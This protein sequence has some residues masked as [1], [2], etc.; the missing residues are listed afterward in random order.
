MTDSNSRI[1]IS[2]TNKRA[3]IWEVDDIAVIRSKYRICGI[4]TGTLPHVSQQNVFLGVPL[5]LMPEEVVLLVENE[6]AVLVDDPNAYPEPS[7]EQITEWDSAR[8]ESIQKQLN[9][10]ESLKHASSLNTRSMSEEAIRKRRERKQRKTIPAEE[11]EPSLKMSMSGHPVH[12]IVIPAS[13][14]STKWYSPGTCTYASIDS[15]KAAGI[16][17]YPS[18]LHERAKCGVFRSLWEQGY[19]MG[20]GIKFGGDYLVYP[21]DPMRY[22][23]HFTATVI[24]SPL[25]ALQPMEIVAHGRLGTATKKAHLICCWDDKKKEVTLMSIEW[26][27]FG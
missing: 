23:S 15:A 21:G 16:W 1:S 6:S 8:L 5:S 7:L 26:G 9:I 12:S 3:F 10:T 13:S 19:F 17:D 22:H 2:V 24:D 25:S 4:L 14:S 27:G 20:G 11:T 18:N